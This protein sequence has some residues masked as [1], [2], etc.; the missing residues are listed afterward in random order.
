MSEWKRLQRPNTCED[1]AIKDIALIRK[2][3]NRLGYDASDNCIEWAWSEWCEENYAATWMDPQ[4][5]KEGATKC[6]N[7]VIAMLVPV[8]QEGSQ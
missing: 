3:M 6:A 5:F 7:E 4:F 2:E 8:E 1:W